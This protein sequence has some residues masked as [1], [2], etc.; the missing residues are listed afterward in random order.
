MVQ[1]IQTLH[2]CVYYPEHKS[3]AYKLYGKDRVEGQLK[4]PIECCNTCEMFIDLLTFLGIREK[5]VKCDIENVDMIID[6]QKKP[7][8]SRSD[9]LLGVRTELI[10]REPQTEVSMEG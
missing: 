7:I 6:H 8:K 3:M 5:D 10:Y 1:T 9:H 2:V 4:D